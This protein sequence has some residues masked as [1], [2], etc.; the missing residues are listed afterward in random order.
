MSGLVMLSISVPIKAQV[1]IT[2]KD[3]AAIVEQVQGNWHFDPANARQ[4]PKPFSVRVS[5][6]PDGK[7]EKVESVDELINDH[8]EALY[9]TFRRA[10]FMADKFKIPAGI[11]LTSVDFDIDPANLID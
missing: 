2:E 11:T 8:C 3:F 4:C 7:V 10:I 9:E 1:P 6:A 5:L